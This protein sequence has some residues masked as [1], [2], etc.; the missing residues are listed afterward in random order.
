MQDQDYQSLMGNQVLQASRSDLVRF[1]HLVFRLPLHLYSSFTQPSSTSSSSSLLTPHNKGQSKMRGQLTRRD[2]PG[3]LRSVLMGSDYSLPSVQGF[4]WDQ[5][6]LRNNHYDIVY[7][8]YRPCTALPRPSWPCVCQPLLKPLVKNK[9]Y[10]SM[11]VRMIAW[12]W[13][14]FKVIEYYSF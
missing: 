9:T 6:N 3:W 5:R 14:I 8:S 1:S 10:C 13:V 12:E 7:V 2:L 4:L 11:I